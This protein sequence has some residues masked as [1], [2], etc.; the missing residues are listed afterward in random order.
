ML[1]KSDVSR[2]WKWKKMC[3]P[4]RRCTSIAYFILEVKI[5]SASS[6]SSSFPEE[7]DHRVIESCR[8]EYQFD[9]STSPRL[10]EPSKLHSRRKTRDLTFSPA[11]KEGLPPPE[12]IHDREMILSSPTDQKLKQ[13]IDNG[14]ERFSQVPSDL[15]YQQFVQLTV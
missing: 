14:W 5:R 2:I 4:G 15:V 9:P 6:R 13:N 1:H 12:V 3:L 8:G 11:V 10:I 7:A